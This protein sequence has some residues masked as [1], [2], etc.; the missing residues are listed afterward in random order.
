MASSSSFG[1]LLI[2]HICGTMLFTYT[3]YHHL[4]IKDPV[5][6]Y[7]GGKFKFLTFLN[8]LIQLVYFT[9]AILGDVVTLI[10][11]REGWLIKLRDILFASLAFPI[12]VFV[13]ATFWGIYLMDRDLIFPKGM[14]EIIPPW[15]NHLLDNMGQSCDW[16]LGLS[17]SACDVLFCQN[18]FRCFSW[19]CC[20]LILFLW[21]KDDKIYFWR[22]LKNKR[23]TP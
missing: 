19:L 21:K 1:I 20:G 16:F 22:Q 8:V 9:T 15:L 11:C 6:P 7:Y 3:L 5:S 2:S 13:S 23:G 14:E 18:S 12:C 17:F 10:K 4:Q